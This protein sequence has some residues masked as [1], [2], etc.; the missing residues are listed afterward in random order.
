MNKQQQKQKLQQKLTPQQI[1]LM[2]LLQ[3]PTTTLEQTIKEEIEKNPLLE[4][5]PPNEEGEKEEGSFD[6]VPVESS[7]SDPNAPDLNEIF[8]DDTLDEYYRSNQEHDPNK[9]AAEYYITADSSLTEQLMDQLEMEELDDRQMTIAQELVGSLDDS[10]YLARDIQL[11]L[12][13]LAFRQ[14]IEASEKEVMD[15]LRII[16]SLDPAGIGAR[17]LQECLALQI[18]RIPGSRQTAAIQLAA[19]IIDKHFDTFANHNYDT[20]QQQLGIDEQQLQEAIACIRQLNPTPTDGSDSPQQT[21]NYITPD[22][23][24]TLEDGKP[25]LTIN[26]RNLPQLH[27]SSYYENMLR[28]MQSKKSSSRADQEAVQFLKSR[29]ANAQEFIDA[30]KQRRSTLC[31][32]MQVILDAQKAYFASGDSADIKPLK[33]KDVAEITGLDLSTISRVVNSKYVQTPFGTTL[34]KK[35]FS[36]AVETES[37]DLVAVAKVKKLLLAAIENEDKQHPI[38]DDELAQQLNQQGFNLARRTIAKYRESLGIPVARLRR[39]IKSLLFPILLALATLMQAQS[40]TYYDSLIIRQTQ[41]PKTSQNSQHPKHT[42]T[43]HI[44]HH[45]VDSSLLHSDEMIDRIYREN[46]KTMPSFLWYGSNFSDTRVRLGNLSMDSL[47]DEVNIRLLKEGETFCFPIKNIITS[48]YGWRWNRPHRGVD[49]RLNTG[50]PVHCAFNG[51]VRI[52]RPMG[53]YGNLVVV[54]HYNG[55]ETVYGHLSKINVKPMQEVKA[56]DILGLGGST[57][58]STGPHLHFEVRF[59]YEPFDPEWI[60]DFG[61]YSLRTQRLHL[62]KTYF[63]ISKPHQGQELA[64]KADKSYV[65]EDQRTRQKPKEIYYTTRRG[66]TLE[67]IAQNYH[68]TPDKIRSLNEGFHKIKPGIRLRVR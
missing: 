24:I 12:N 67:S 17:S 60:L 59:Q 61:S 49:I 37:G 1:M 51:V 68:T 6:D 10:G 66:D 7:E 9:T 16:Q 42:T 18:R 45:T 54:R 11:I 46:S 27:I 43:P 13:D 29:S 28:E 58:H 47:P 26:E 63:G 48:P 19:R 33:Q 32:V 4:M 8:D 57:G 2:K 36:S 62:D 35:F 5:D 56:G 30:L 41:K 15:V 53:G 55:L 52:A 31:D 44:D 40:P 23:I 25:T 22:F 34:L 21:H 65:K 64:Y 20:L 39:G 14:G 3:M 38:T 50:D